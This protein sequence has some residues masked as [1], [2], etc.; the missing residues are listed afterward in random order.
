[1][2]ENFTASKDTRNLLDPEKANAL[3][4]YACAQDDYKS[5]ALLLMH[6]ANPFVEDLLG[7]NAF[8]I[9]IKTRNNFITNL[10]F[11]A[12]RHEKEFEVDNFLNDFLNHQ[13]ESQALYYAIK[14]N[15]HQTATNI[16][17][18]YP[19]LKFY[20]IDPEG[21]TPIHCVAML[22]GDVEMAKIV[23]DPAC[24]KVN[25]GNDYVD[26]DGNS[27]LNL[28][29]LQGR[30]DEMIQFLL[31]R[32]YYLDQPDFHGNG[33]TPEAYLQ[34]RK[35]V[36]NRD[37]NSV[38]SDLQRFPQLINYPLDENGNLA[39]HVVYVQADISMRDLLIKNGS[40]PYAPNKFGYSAYDIVNAGT[41]VDPV[42][43]AKIKKFRV[44]DE[45]L[46][47][48][49]YLDNRRN[50]SEPVTVETIAPKK[51]LFNPYSEPHNERE[52][53]F[54]RNFVNPQ[55]IRVN[56]QQNNSSNADKNS[57][58]RHRKR[59]RTILK[60]EAELPIV[61]PVPQLTNVQNE[62]ENKLLAA[63]REPLAA[64][65][66][67]PT[68]IEAQ[69]KAEAAKI[70]LQGEE[71]S[72]RLR[73]LKVL[74][75]QLTKQSEKSFAD[76]VERLSDEIA[77]EITDEMG[78]D[79][80]IAEE[81]TKNLPQESVKAA[82]Q[83]EEKSPKKKK[84]K[85]K[86]TPDQ[87]EELKVENI[88]K[89]NDQS[90]PEPNPVTAAPISSEP[91]KPV[92]SSK[93]EMRDRVNQQDEKG[94]TALTKLM[95]EQNKE[96][97][98]TKLKKLLDWG[99]DINAVNSS[100]L[101]PL[102]LAVNFK[103]REFAEIL[104]QERAS[105]ESVNKEGMTP[106]LSSCKSGDSETYQ[107]LV[108]AGANL[109]AADNDGMTALM[110]ASMMGHAAIVEDLITQ[111]VDL[112]TQD[113]IGRTALIWAA[114]AEEVEISKTLIRAGAKRNIKTTDG[115]S[116]YTIAYDLGFPQDVAPEIVKKSEPSD[117][118]N[119]SFT[120]PSSPTAQKNSSQGKSA[121]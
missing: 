93:D 49:A 43:E 119:P 81:I 51:K 33:V 59:H 23:Y 38:A 65:I 112:D 75:A 82:A 44:D 1:M 22:S 79:K 55:E 28:A 4:H 117:I 30:S 64:P 84:K 97:F 70:A 39:I 98:H 27:A 56:T 40:H 68:E 37:E 115:E 91:K 116:F 87:Q 102:S 45:I 11:H 69:H 89:S 32:G 2:K 46:R 77:Q 63:L 62:K 18:Q 86:K 9:A 3:L 19:L 20:G 17:H 12:D 78:L 13:Q 95:N 48:G 25:N 113:V 50:K 10:L 53:K 29:C 34:F 5:A 109:K 8:D 76:L 21:R 96:V 101:T 26:F 114:M 120:K 52:K 71:D 24:H 104:I 6:G 60:K 121:S 105:L 100:G 92:R 58:R 36:K 66:A 35:D 57:A 94:E 88:E 106:L 54:D 85:K 72:R 83:D 110:I 47:D 15:D 107:M 108:K 42:T 41:N 7:R 111:K 118:P 103:N 73:E 90:A 16:L 67:L 14:E 74:S 99:A 31:E 80:L 61:P